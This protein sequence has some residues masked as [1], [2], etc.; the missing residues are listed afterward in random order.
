MMR[1][2]ATGSLKLNR[3]L[4]RYVEKALEEGRPIK[5]GWGQ[6]GDEKPK[7]GEFGVITH[8]PE[9]ARVQCL[10]NLGDFSG[11]SNLGGTFTLLG[12]A[13]SM[14]GAF[15]SSGRTVVE[16]SVGDTV[17]FKMNG[18]EITIQGSVGEAAGAGMTGGLLLVRGHASGEIG[19]GMSGGTILVMGSVGTNPG[20]GMVGGRIIVSGSCPPPSD[21][22]QMRSIKKSEISEFGDKLGPLGLELSGDALVLESEQ[23]TPE[24]SERPAAFIS[25][26]FEKI[27]LVPNEDS[28]A[29]HTPL[30]HYTLILSKDSSSPGIGLQIPWLLECESA[31]KWEGELLQG[32]PAIVRTEPRDVDL[33]LVDDKS[34]QDAPTNL[35][36]CAGLVLDIT[37]FPGFNDA[38]IEAILVSLY[39]RMSEAGIVFLRGSIDRLDR[40]FRLVTE[41]EVDGAI[42]NCASNGG[43][44]MAASLPNIGLANRAMRVSEIGKFVFLEMDDPPEARGILIALAAGCHGIVAPCLGDA[45]GELVRI[46]SELR[47]WMLEIGIDRIERIGR[48]N[49]RAIDFETA[50]ISGLRLVGF[51]RPLPMWLEGR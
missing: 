44:R 33:L 31:D 14:F 51:E 8:L 37:A 6:A 36:S 2:L 28:L 23:G 38:Q 5:I 19:S 13:T 47:G 16:K 30:D 34:I 40:L 42:V 27:S 12:S 3:D 17:A 15:H 43:T 7:D 49:L 1:E 9:G 25:E 26:G 45:E 20:I 29:D 39:S 41:L 22:V 4:D 35:G 48:R 24:I 10:G 21:G 46:S 18:G 50:A 11:A 32:T